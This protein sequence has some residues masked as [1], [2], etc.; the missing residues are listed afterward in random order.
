MHLKTCDI[1]HQ[2]EGELD[3]Y[4]DTH[5]SMAMLEKSPPRLDR[6][7]G[8]VSNNK[9]NQILTVFFTD[10]HGD[11]IYEKSIKYLQDPASVPSLKESIN[12]EPNI[13][14]CQMS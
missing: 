12:L 7:L 4:G 2:S 11:T 3:Q 13:T 1:I 5:K 9:V 6:V 10:F 14:Q 8:L